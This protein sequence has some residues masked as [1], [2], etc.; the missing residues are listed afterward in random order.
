[1]CIE[2]II[3]TSYGSLI[4]NK[5]LHNRI[6]FDKE[7]E[8]GLIYPY[9]EGIFKRCYDTNGR[10]LKNIVLL[11]N[12]ITPGSY[13]NVKIIGGCTFK[14]NDII[15]DYMISVP[16]SIEYPNN[17]FELK[18]YKLEEIKSFILNYNKSKNER[19]VFDGFIVSESANRFYNDSII[20]YNRTEE[21]ENNT[22]SYVKLNRS[23]SK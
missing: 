18:S 6:F 20:R 14:I 12:K 11:Y 13:I 3:I 15:Q 8:K 17:I 10:Y 22:E 23:Q 7:L 2:S 1:M 21:K 16:C 4:K 9:N 5:F 19:I